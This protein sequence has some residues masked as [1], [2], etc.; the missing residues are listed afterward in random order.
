MKKLF[1]F[2]VGIVLSFVSPAHAYIV[3][4]TVSYSVTNSDSSDARFESHVFYESDAK[5]DD[6]FVGFVTIFPMT[7]DYRDQNQKAGAEF[8]CEQMALELASH[9]FFV[10]IVNYQDAYSSSQVYDLLGELTKPDVNAVDRDSFVGRTTR[11]LIPILSQRYKVALES[12][13]RS[14]YGGYAEK[15]PHYITGGSLGGSV[16]FLSTSLLP[17]DWQ[18]VF[19]NFSSAFVETTK[20][21]PILTDKLGRVAQ[22]ISFMHTSDDTIAP[23]AAVENLVARLKQDGI[24]ARFSPNAPRSVDLTDSELVHSLYL[25]DC[26]L[27]R[28]NDL[29]PLSREI[30]EASCKYRREPEMEVKA[31][32][33]PKFI[34][35]NPYSFLKIPFDVTY[36]D[37]EDAL[38]EIVPESDEYR[39]S[40]KI[41]G[42]LLSYHYEIDL[43]SMTFKP[44]SNNKVDI[45]ID[46]SGGLKFLWGLAQDSAEV[47]VAMEMTSEISP[48]WEVSLELGEPRC[49]W[50][51]KLSIATRAMGIVGS[52]F[53]NLFR[54][55]LKADDPQ[56]IIASSVEDAANKLRNDFNAKARVSI[57]P[58]LERQWKRAHES[59]SL[60]DSP[61]LFLNVTPIFFAADSLQFFEDKLRLDLALEAGLELSLR[62]HDVAVKELP[63]NRPIPQSEEDIS[64]L[65]PLFVPHNN[66]NALFA[67]YFEKNPLKLQLLGMK[68]FVK[69]LRIENRDGSLSLIA[70][71]YVGPFGDGAAQ[72]K[73]VHNLEFTLRLTYDKSRRLFYFSINPLSYR[74]WG[75]LE[76]ALVSVMKGQDINY[77]MQWL[78]LL[79]DNKK[80]AY[81]SG[82]AIEKHRKLLDAEIAKL[83][84]GLLNLEGGFINAGLGDLR[85]G[86]EGLSLEL[87]LRGG[88]ISVD[89]MGI[90]MI[91]LAMENPEW[92]DRNG[93]TLLDR[94]IMAEKRYIVGELVKLGVTSSD[95]SQ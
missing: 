62:S 47:N 55:K 36:K 85:I 88:K 21:E 29:S 23:F 78:S 32:E 69:S 5:Q 70:P 65:V 17:G 66:M 72:D 51:N 86:R 8:L 92:K 31:R 61:S 18:I 45:T 25:A 90:L 22:G 63:N 14:E 80:F 4:D 16:G 54:A 12:L 48:E 57:R 49:H 91:S 33:E 37:L 13:V 27:Q 79:T 73:F 6:N 41:A 24:D 67:S 58:E 74:E 89:A 43:D 83:G 82:P 50:G 38:P 42:G 10:W 40:G 19:M 9:K 52:A 56:K 64:L 46:L 15:L 77:V 76:K 1:V 28:D 94:A 71:L 34:A 68:F 81:N 26:M 87:F 39:G 30:I 53:S 3:E 7:L 35:P 84:E 60:A 2:Y 44:V 20:F 95:K 11:T 93:H 59:F 75:A